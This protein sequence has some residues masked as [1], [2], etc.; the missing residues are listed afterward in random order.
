MATKQGQTYSVDSLTYRPSLFAEGTEDVHST[1]SGRNEIAPM[2][3]IV[4]QYTSIKQA[5]QERDS[6]QKKKAQ[7]S[8]VRCGI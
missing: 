3:V 7:Q 2:F 1:C 4:D 5:H 8:Q 6:L